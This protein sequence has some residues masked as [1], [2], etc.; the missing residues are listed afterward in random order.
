MLIELK[1][2]LAN[3]WRTDAFGFFSRGQ[4]SYLVLPVAIAPFAS[5]GLD[6]FLLLA[7]TL[8]WPVKGYG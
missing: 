8:G 6:W 3:R 4:V 2:S 7:T 5:V 1:L